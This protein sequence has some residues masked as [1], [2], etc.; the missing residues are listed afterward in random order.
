MTTET[1]NPDPKDPEPEP[2]PDRGD[3]TLEEQT[4]IETEGDEPAEDK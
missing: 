1:Q 3:Q 2:E 4:E